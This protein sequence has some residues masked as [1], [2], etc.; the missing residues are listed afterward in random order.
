M[1][2][3]KTSAL[4]KFLKSKVPLLNKKHSITQDQYDQIREDSEAA[5]EI[6]EDPRFLFL[7]EYMETAKKSIVQLFVENRLKPT[8]EYFFGR[9][10]VK[11]HSITRR[12]SENEASGQY[13]FIDKLLHDLQ[14]TAELY[15]MYKKDIDSGRVTIEGEEDDE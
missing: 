14:I 7:R 6:L 9:E 5:K 8:K 4:Q 2:I 3:K 12:E 1:E 10:T 13:K 15:D 11:E